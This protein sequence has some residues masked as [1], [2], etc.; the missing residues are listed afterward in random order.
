[1]NYQFLYQAADAK[2]V[3]RRIRKTQLAIEE[4]LLEL[5]ETKR[6]EEITVSELSIKADIN[7]KTFYNH[8]TS[9]EEIVDKIENDFFQYIFSFL[10][11][12]I[13]MQN[14]IE[15]YNFL[16]KI[17]GLLDPY[18]DLLK[19]LYENN[20]Q[21]I[22]EERFSEQLEPYIKKCMVAYNVNPLIIPYITDYI[23]YGASGL[24]TRWLASGS[25]TSNEL[26]MLTYN[27]LLSS[28]HLEN[29]RDVINESK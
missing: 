16:Q 12:K 28:L 20:E 25:I 7:R 26:A 6:I 4:A 2:K 23:L 10:P 18:R 21:I 5:M 27:L 22:F 24:F 13:T 11:D 1:M 17:I 3:D 19:K 14:T 15:I 9:I 8:F 29:F